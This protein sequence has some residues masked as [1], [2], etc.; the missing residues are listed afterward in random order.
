MPRTAAVLSTENAAGRVLEHPAGYVV[1]AY[2]AGPRRLADLQALIDRTGQLLAARGWYL[3]LGDQRLMAPLAPEESAWLASYWRTHTRQHPGPLFA[4][5]VLAQDV[6][7]RLSTT[8]LRSEMRDANMTYRQ[9]AD[10]AAAEA[11][12]TQQR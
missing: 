12:L 6:F 8:Q 10:E 2:K 11:W 1:F 5:V 7:A 9:F 3:I 4:A